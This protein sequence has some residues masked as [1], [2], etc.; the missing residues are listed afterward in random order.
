MIGKVFISR[1]NR[2]IPIFIVMAITV[3]IITII[4]YT[5]ILPEQVSI[6][7]FD[8]NTVLGNSSGSTS[9]QLAMS[10]NNGYIAWTE[11]SAGNHV[12]KFSKNQNG[13]IFAKPMYISD[14]GG[15]SSNRQIAASG[16]NVYIVWVNNTKQ[17]GN[18]IYFS[19]GDNGTTF[20]K[21]ERISDKGGNSS[22][23]QIAASG[24]NVYIVW[25][26]NTK[27]G[28]SDIYFSKGEN[29][30]IFTKP[31][32]ISGKKG[33]SSNPQIAASGNNVYVTWLENDIGKNASTNF[34]LFFRAS[35][36]QGSYFNDDKIIDK[37]TG[38][39]PFLPRVTASGNN[40]Y[41]TWVDNTTQG[42]SEIYFSKGS[43]NGTTF[44]K[45]ERI[46]DRKENSSY[47]QFASSGNNTYVV[48]TEHSPGNDNVI[49]AKGNG[50]T[51]TKPERLSD[52]NGSS[53]LPQLAASENIIGTVWMD[54][55]KILFSESTNNGERFTRPITLSNNSAVA[56][57][58]QLAVSGKDAYVVWIENKS[59]INQIIFKQVVTNLFPH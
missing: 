49:F 11:W 21:P 58:P 3:I 42:G 39:I 56:Y 44:T 18:D 5:K 34:R 25:V 37:K 48:W 36:T 47:P 45:P 29:G 7:L 50:T 27:Q 24:N 43:D 9:P 23:R 4:L 10:G 51:F 1:I 13:T 20:T 52:K 16:N 32:L 14:K 30:S 41:L 59:G 31:E 17:G 54:H 35:T 38:Q 53:S 22:N 12:I 28:G 40:V 46:S 6:I 8:K 26:N 2:N 19:K 33:N 57:S 15:N 55:N